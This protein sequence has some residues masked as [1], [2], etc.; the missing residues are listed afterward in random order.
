M[1][2]H[3]FGENKFL[4]EEAA[5]V[6]ALCDCIQL[7]YSPLQGAVVDHAYPPTIV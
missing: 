2:H 1:F 6:I 4:V 7:Y 5:N 3:N